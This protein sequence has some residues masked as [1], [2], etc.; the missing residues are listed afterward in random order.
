MAPHTSTG[1]MYT[2]LVLPKG[3]IQASQEPA[4]SSC[5]DAICGDGSVEGI[6]VLVWKWL[7][8]KR[9]VKTTFWRDCFWQVCIS[10]FQ[11]QKSSRIH[12][13]PKWMPVMDEKVKV[14]KSDSFECYLFFAKFAA[15][16]AINLRQHRR[17]NPMRS[18]LAVQDVR[19]STVHVACKCFGYGE[20]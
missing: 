19:P 17:I 1:R 3:E 15:S 5:S 13:N 7:P 10:C 6:K 8:T 9:L 2:Q 20:D 16:R 14:C 12:R 18:R 11:L 4:H